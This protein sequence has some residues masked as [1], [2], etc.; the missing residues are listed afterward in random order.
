M[1]QVRDATVIVPT[2][3]RAAY[4]PECLD[5]LL[6][7]TVAPRQLVVL[8][9]GSTDAT[10][11]VAASYVERRGDRSER[12]RVEYVRQRN[13]GKAAALNAALGHATGQV[14]W[15]FDDDD[16]AH[17]RA[18]EWLSD[19]LSRAPDAGFAFGRH[20]YFAADPGGRKRFRAAAPR[21]IAVDDLFFAI[22][23]GAFVFQGGMLARRRLYD[24]VG[25]FDINFPRAQDRE[26]LH[27]LAQRYR[28][29]AV[30]RVVFHQ[31]QHL[32]ERG[33]AHVR[34]G[35]PE[36][37]ARQGVFDRQAFRK[38]HG[39]TP[40]D[41][42]LP[43][44]EREAL[45]RGAPFT[46]ARQ[47]RALVRRAVCMAHA[48]VWEPV[49]ADLRQAAEIGRGED[50]AAL[51]AQTADL[52]ALVFDQDHNR[53]E[54]R[55]RAAIQAIAPMSDGSCLEPPHAPIE[56]RHL[57]QIVEALLWPVFRAGM[58]ALLRGRVRR[59]H[60][61]FSLY[62]TRSGPRT[63]A[64]HLLRYV[65]YAPRRLWSRVAPRGP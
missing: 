26:M 15:I 17:P 25:P 40:L 56:S 60:G 14:V 20:D 23:T 28:A 13:G 8:D 33:P 42:Y 52:Y 47:V 34:M 53:V 50:V 37:W 16:I 11:Q 31:R 55:I 32:G 51:F 2:Y 27:R 6:A 36:A 30:D 61:A 65:R 24:E 10:A 35:G 9:D 54:E 43:W 29:V 46:P 62:W 19:A 38:T 63:A 48:D 58:N 57:R 45:A 18:L 59:S 22:L 3:N 41:R 64:R 4:L 5:S 39:D 7:Q 44:P 21:R 1:D 49:V 12:T